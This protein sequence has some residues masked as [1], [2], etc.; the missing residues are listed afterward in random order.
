MIKSDTAPFA[1]FLCTVCY[2]IDKDEEQQE[3][4]HCGA[5]KCYIK[6]HF[7]QAG[8]T[9]YRQAVEV[10]LNEMLVEYLKLKNILKAYDWLP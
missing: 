10:Y 3:C 8:V 5:V 2:R 4:Q 9:T 7:H 1:L 6:R